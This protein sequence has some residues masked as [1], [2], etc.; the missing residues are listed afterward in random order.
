M[1]RVLNGDN[2]GKD[3]GD[4]GEE[5]EEGSVSAE[6]MVEIVFVGE[7]SVDSGFALDSLPNDCDVKGP[8]GEILLGKLVVVC[9][10]MLPPRSFFVSRPSPNTDMNDGKDASSDWEPVVIGMVGSQL[11]AGFVCERVVY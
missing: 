2:G 9:A 1:Y 3:V 6:S 4:S 8:A 5:A 7:E 11:L 10:P